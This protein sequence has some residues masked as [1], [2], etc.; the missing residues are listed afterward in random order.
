MIN[1]ADIRKQALKNQGLRDMATFASFDEVIASIDAQEKDCWRNVREKFGDKPN[2]KD[3]KVREA[4]PPLTIKDDL[5]NADKTFFDGHLEETLAE[6]IL[7]ANADKGLLATIERSDRI[8]IERANEDL[9]ANE[10]RFYKPYLFKNA[11]K[12][13]VKYPQLAAITGGEA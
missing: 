7:V 5:R 12:L 6:M 1:L 8:T 11:Y 13:A 9:L 2:F 4:L 3:P 10:H